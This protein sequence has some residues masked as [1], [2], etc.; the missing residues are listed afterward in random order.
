MVEGFLKAAFHGRGIE[1]PT[2][3]PR[4]TFDE[5]MRNYGIDKPDLR[6]PALTDVKAAFHW[7]IW[8]RGDDT[9]LPVVA[10]HCPRWASSRRKERDDNRPR[11][12]TRKGAS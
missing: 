8:Q 10:V 5:A 12:D 4:M 2:R 1:L 9:G 11:F 6:L 7:G 3:F